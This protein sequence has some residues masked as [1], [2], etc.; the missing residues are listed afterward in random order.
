MLYMPRSGRRG[1]FCRALAAAAALAVAVFC[2]QGAQAFDVKKI[3]SGVYKIYTER[4]NGMGTGTGFL[5]NGRRILVTNFHVVVDGEKFYVGY[6]DGRDGRLVE[7]RVVDRRSHI[8]LAVLETYEDLPG[9]PLTIGD[10][11]PEKLTNVVAIGFPGA[12]DVMK[13]GAI[14]NRTE[15]FAAMKEPSGLDSTITPGMVS[16]IYSATNT[17]LTQTQV[18]NARTVQHNAPI[19]PGN[20]GGPLV[21]ECGAVVGVNSFSPKGAQGV[22]FS[23]HSAEVIRFLRE[24]NIA[25]ASVGKT[26]LMGSLSG[27]SGL[28]LPIMIGMAVTLAVVAVLFAWRGGA[29]VGAVGQYVSRRFTGIRKREGDDPERRPAK[30]ELPRH[31]APPANL[32]ATAAALALQPSAGGSPFALEVG[33]TV[34]IGRGRQCGIILNDDTVSSN[35]AR[36]EPD[37]KGNQVTI[38]DLNSSNGTYLNGKRIT[39]AVANVG[40]LLR[41]GS[42]E[43][44]LTAGTLVAGKAGYS[45]A[46]GWMLSGFDTRGRAL[47]FELRPQ[48]ENGRA[49]DGKTWTIGR[50]RNRAQ[51][52]IDDDSVSG[53][54]AQI[55]YEAR[56]GLTLRDLGSTNG[57]K[58]DGA[59]LGS[60][61][62][63]LSDTGQ[64]ITF[65][66]AKLRLS[67]LIR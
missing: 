63:S 27:G 21:D 66:A 42:A 33:K 57:T 47:Q 38:A 64:E 60:R 35:H 61:A 65:G 1:R 58:I 67:R 25:Y 3:E 59:P 29:A 32:A 39:N 5:V 4:K 19:N 50:D 54:H 49:V 51:F 17:A 52:V 20:S 62:V 2:T 7:A 56:Q 9:R 30:R 24:L 31:A 13:P 28:V 55:T 37:I 8:D 44:K 53:A 41:F 18:L 11:E 14:H 34:V 12:A 48:A 16:R 10:Y 26:C 40:D 6:R 43:F 23:I 36:L 15:L 46:P 45:A 22:F